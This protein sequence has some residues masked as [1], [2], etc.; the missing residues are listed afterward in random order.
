MS[1]AVR[2][3]RTALPSTSQKAAPPPRAGARSFTG[4]QER[5]V[6]G[7]ADAAPRVTEMAN[8]ECVPTMPE[9]I[10][11]DLRRLLA[12]I[13]VRDYLGD[14]QRDSARFGEGPEPDAIPPGSPRRP[15]R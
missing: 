6:R 15:T 11:R 1:T 12:E 4:S 2:R 13:L 10:A 8:G 14:Q 5:A 7:Q 3:N 9:T